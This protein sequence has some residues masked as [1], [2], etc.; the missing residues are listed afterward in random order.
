MPH[1]QDSSISDGLK[2]SLEVIEQAAND[3]G[4][5]NSILM[6][7]LLPNIDSFAFSLKLSKEDEKLLEKMV[8]HSI[9]KQQGRLKA[10]KAAL[11]DSVRKLNA[12]LNSNNV[13]IERKQ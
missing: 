6:F 11:D 10:I 12:E 13:E 2:G 9:R 1:H 3:I 8:K 5:V 4:N 7:Q